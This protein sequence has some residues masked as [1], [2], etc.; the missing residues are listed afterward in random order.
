MANGGDFISRQNGRFEMHGRLTFASV[1]SLLAGARQWQQDSAHDI[2]IDMQAVSHADSAGLAL[3]VEW[4]NL[5]QQQNR[6]LQFVNIPVQLSNL[7][8]ISGLEQLIPVN[9]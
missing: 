8:R 9:H 5:A 1:P 2:V 4:L 7:I 3:M 6:K